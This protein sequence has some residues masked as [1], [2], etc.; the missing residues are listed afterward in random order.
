MPTF[1]ETIK[2]SGLPVE[3]GTD[4]C[5]CN[6]GYTLMELIHSASFSYQM[7]PHYR[8]L[9]STDWLDSRSRRK[10]HGPFEGFTAIQIH[11]CYTCVT[12]C[13]IPAVL[14]FHTWIALLSHVVSVQYST[15]Y[16]KWVFNAYNTIESHFTHGCKCVLHCLS[17]IRIAR[18]TQH[19][20]L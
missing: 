6:F 16:K 1:V 5:S 19:I 14:I 7:L 4:D 9:N 13:Y 17:T 11:Q 12:F 18:N 15:H 3:F 8:I 2:F 10:C 20:I